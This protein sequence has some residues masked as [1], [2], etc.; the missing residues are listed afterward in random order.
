M[1]LLS[2]VDYQAA[3]ILDFFDSVGN[4]EVER[5]IGCERQLWEIVDGEVLVDFLRVF[6]YDVA[7]LDEPAG[8]DPIHGHGYR[9][10]PRTSS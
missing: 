8:M 9:W 7:Q 10:Y 5:S 1:K 6:G 4:W 3:G 2:R